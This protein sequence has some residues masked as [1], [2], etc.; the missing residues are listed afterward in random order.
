MKKHLSLLLVVLL[1]LSAV[2]YPVYCSAASGESRTN[3]AAQYDGIRDFLS[4]LQYMQGM[5]LLVMMYGKQSSKTT[6]TLIQIEQYAVVLWEDAFYV[7]VVNT[8]GGFVEGTY[9]FSTGEYYVGGFSSNKRSG[10]GTAYF[11]NGD[12]YIGEW[13]NDKMNGNGTYYFGGL[14][15]SEYYNGAMVD[16]TRTG[17]GVYYHNGTPITGTW[18]RDL[19]T[20]W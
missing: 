17:N 9:Y 15:S 6:C 20:G 18:N 8:S 5:S 10:K 19:H 14:N 12:V 1:G 7:G 16:N 2:T 3:V 11:S 4:G 13:K